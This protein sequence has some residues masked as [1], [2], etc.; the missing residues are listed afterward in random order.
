MRGD[1]VIPAPIH[2]KA[3]YADRLL[4]NS[5]RQFSSS[6]HSLMRVLFADSSNGE[7][8]FMSDGDAHK[9]RADPVS[10]L[11]V[12]RSFLF[13]MSISPFEP[14]MIDQGFC[15]SDRYMYMKFNDLM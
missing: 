9:S 3:G 5:K 8:Y 10:P 11:N 12:P 13:Y 6:R 4:H 7:E 14:E 2:G 15:A 1:V